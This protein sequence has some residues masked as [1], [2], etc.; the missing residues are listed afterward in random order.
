MS[1][2]RRPT[3]RRAR[4]GRWPPRAS[5]PAGWMRRELAAVFPELRLG[6]DERALH[7]ASGGTVLATEGME[8]MADA[9]TGLGAR[10]IS[11]ERVSAWRSTGGRRRASV[12][13]DAVA[14]MPTLVG[15]RH[16]AVGGRAVDAARGWPAAG[17]RRWLRSPTSTF[18]PWSA[19]P[20]S[21]TGRSMTAAAACT[22]TPCRA[23]A[24]SSRSTRPALSRGA[25][26]RPSGRP[27]RASRRQLVRW[28]ERR[29]PGV[30][31]TVLAERAASL[32]DDARH[33]LRDRSRRPGGGRL[34]LLGPCVQVR[35]GAGR[36]GRRHRPG[37]RPR[38]RRDVLDAPRG[39]VAAD[40]S[41]RPRRSTASHTQ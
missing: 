31:A 18:P 22:A 23:W 20:G 17:A 21:R 37:C 25:R 24:T 39:D 35:A 11:P 10:L 27:T 15:G 28:V 38:G 32:D 36:A 4:G 29:F 3:A 7:H 12:T 33:R 30:D 14:S 34:R 16:R 6:P 13:T 5:R 41:T 26:R 19:G 8:A 40:A 9:A 1:T 2:S